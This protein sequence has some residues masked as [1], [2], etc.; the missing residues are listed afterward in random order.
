MPNTSIEFYENQKRKLAYALMMAGADASPVKHW[1]QGAARALQGAMGG[2][3]AYK[4]DQEDKAATETLK[5]LPGLGFLSPLRRLRL[6][7]WHRRSVF[8]LTSPPRSRAVLSCRGRRCGATRKP[9][10]PGFT[11]VHSLRPSTTD[12]Q[13]SIP[14]RSPAQCSRRRF[15][16]SV[17]AIPRLRSRPS[18]RSVHLL[19]FLPMLPGACGR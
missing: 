4:L 17:S 14:K 8:R 11:Q 12:L 5:N 18:F 15:K 6:R 9:R 2:Y 10:T 19:P 7:R 16:R 1:T 13:G 3:E